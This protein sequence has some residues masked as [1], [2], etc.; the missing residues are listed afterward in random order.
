MRY[1][2][3]RFEDEEFIIL[4]QEVLK[5]GLSME[6]YLKEAVDEKRISD[7]ANTK[8]SKNSSCS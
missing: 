1:A 4:K 5:S 6:K 8:K 7:A 3:I 2:Q